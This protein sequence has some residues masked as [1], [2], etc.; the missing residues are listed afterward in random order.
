VFPC[1]PGGKEPL[2]RRGFKDATTD[3]SRVHA[4]WTRWPG[5]NIGIPT[6]EASGLLVLDEDRVGALS[7]LPGELPET[8]TARTGGGGLH[9]LYRYPAGEEIR[10]S[11]GKLGDGIDV[12]GEGGYVIAPPSRTTGPYEWIER[13]P[14]ADAP[15]WLLEAL[16]KPPARPERSKGERGPTPILAAGEK[17]PDGR[18]DDALASLAGRLHDGTRNLERLT[19]DLMGINASRCAPPLPE[20]E[21]EKIAGSIFKREPAKPSR[22]VSPE[23]LGK[24]DG[25]EDAY[26]WNRKWTGVGWKTPRSAMVALITEAREHGAPTKDGVRVS[27]SVRKLALAVAVS[28]PA[29]IRALNKLEEANIIRRVKG[30][31]TKSGAYVLIEPSVAG[32]YHSSTDAAAPSSGNTLPHPPTAPRLRYSKPVY[33]TID[34]ERIYSHHVLRLGKAAEAVVDI[35]EKNGGWMSAPDIGVTLGIKH[36]RDLRRRTLPRLEAAA[37]VECSGDDVRLRLDWQAA[38][39]RK[40]KDDQEISDY[41]RDEEKYAEESRVY[42]LKLK[43]RKLHRVCGLEEIAATMEIGMEVVYRLLDIP[44]PVTEP[45]PVEPDGFIEDLERVEDPKIAPVEKEIIVAE[46]LSP[47]AVAV[48]LWLERHPRDAHQPAGWIGSTLWTYELHPKLEDPPAETT[49]AIEE[50]GGDAYLRDLKRVAA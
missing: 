41:Y 29:L 14:L 40:R 5:A 30:S 42:A 27:I 3:R 15:A 49:A 11:A 48:R 8:T 7:E 22:D 20:G 34:G 38:L 6:G 35:L 32:R 37:V 46:S 44:R 24:L 13:L 2:T 16:R 25:I 50:L 26:L 19:A 31:G 9:M 17:I 1:R 39:K 28:K 21:V 43:A 47:L 23:V 4:W 36:H 33:E 10:N 45:A 18:R 12:R